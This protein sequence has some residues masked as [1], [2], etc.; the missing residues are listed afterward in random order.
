MFVTMVACGWLLAKS[1]A[2]RR[3]GRRYA[4]G[5]IAFAALVVL[6]FGGLVVAEIRRVGW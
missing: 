4:A 6:T 3:N 5:K 1:I 2:E